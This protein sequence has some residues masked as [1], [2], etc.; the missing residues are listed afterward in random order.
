MSLRGLC[1]NSKHL[2]LANSVFKRYIHCVFTAKKLMRTACLHMIG[3]PYT[4]AT[5][6]GQGRLEE[7]RTFPPNPC[8][9][10]V[11]RNSGPQRSGNDMALQSLMARLIQHSHIPFCRG[12]LPTPPP[13]SRNTPPY[14]TSLLVGTPPSLLPPSA[15]KLTSP[16]CNTQGAG[17]FPPWRFCPEWSDSF[18]TAAYLPACRSIS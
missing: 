3:Q 10:K 18:S 6:R 14:F 4:L 15:G 17:H 9:L 16:G 12:T 13:T 8:N 11:R 2:G 1:R 5:H 7:T